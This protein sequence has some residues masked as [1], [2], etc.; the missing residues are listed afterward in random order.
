MNSTGGKAA[1]RKKYC[2]KKRVVRHA[3]PLFDKW[4]LEWEQEA[5]KCGSNMRFNYRRARNSLKLYP[6]PV[7]RGKDCQVLAHFGDKICQMLDQKLEKH[8][9]ENGPIVW[10]EIHQV[11][12]SSVCKKKPR[13]MTVRK[14]QPPAEKTTE[15]FSDTT[16]GPGVSTTGRGKGRPYVP[17]FRSGAYALLIALYN[18]TK[19]SDDGFMKKRQLME[20]AQ[21]LCNGSFTHASDGSHYTAW[22]SMGTLIKKNLVV[23]EGNP[24][25]YSL[26][27]DGKGLAVRLIA[28]GD[29]DSYATSNILASTAD[30]GIDVV[31]LSSRSCSPLSSSSSPVKNRKFFN[32]N[33]K[34]ESSF[35]EKESL[36]S[37]IPESEIM[38]YNDIKG[39]C[40]QRKRKNN[41][42]DTGNKVETSIKKSCDS[43]IFSYVTSL[44]LETP[45]KDKAVVSVEDD[46]FLGFLIKCRLSDLLNSS[47]S[48]RVD[49]DRIAPLG[50]TYAYL[51]NDCAPNQSPGLLS[52]RQKPPLTSRIPDPADM[53]SKKPDKRISSKAKITSSRSGMP[54]KPAVSLLENIVPR[55]DL[56][57][58]ITSMPLVKRFCEE[59]PVSSKPLFSFTPGM[60]E[61]V[62]CVD[63]A[64]STG[65]FQG[66][67]K[68][69]TKEIFISELKKHRVQYDIRKL[70][71]GDFLWIARERSS[72]QSSCSEPKELVL[73]YIVERKRMDDL[74][75][76]IR[77]GRFKEQKFR[78]KQSGLSNPIYLVEEYGSQNLSLPESTCLQAITNTQVVDGFTVKVTKDQI[79]SAAFL[80]IMTR[81]LQSRYQGKNLKSVGLEDLQ[82]RGK[83][84]NG[85]IVETA[86]V[87]FKDFNVAS[88]KNH[89]LSVKEMFVK[90]LLQLHGL[91]VD[92]AKALVD[93]YETPAALM[94]AYESLENPVESVN[95]LTSVKCG[96]A[97]RNFGPALSMHVAK[98]YTNLMLQ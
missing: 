48:Y 51:S 95:L 67:A 86:L 27:H 77:D 3:N 24:A 87:P 38:I 73:P 29:T 88:M 42:N 49:G 64:E 97:G 93:K 62:L 30:S 65:G 18:S 20:A 80:T 76:S 94:S 16:S 41:S 46:G 56:K 74:A 14:N 55:Q 79:E 39:K 52:P 92:K 59:T 9:D 63:N 84:T 8:I 6:L 53:E 60:Y 35:A 54:S 26:T 47:L 22:S 68:L 75:K 57:S 23:R 28:G 15:G 78:L 69:N 70:H 81:C 98:L 50:F 32:S 43:F 25:R 31:T 91:S 34:L 33:T 61:I 83:L 11:I 19:E 90:H 45:L 72:F 96:K 82:N 36:L 85:E 44:E 21:P 37:S 40:D 2:R 71:I 17:S 89:Q 10:E 7:Y 58:S 5:A 4:L 12:G 66:M 1:P 13:K